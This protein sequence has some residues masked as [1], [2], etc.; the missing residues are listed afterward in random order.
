M[1]WNENF[2]ASVSS[3]WT[4]FNEGLCCKSWVS[5]AMDNAS[6]Y[7]LEDSWLA[8]KILKCLN[9]YAG[10]LFQRL[11][12]TTPNCSQGRHLSFT[13]NNRGRNKEFYGVISFYFT[14]S[15]PL[16]LYDVCR[17]VR[18]LL[19]EKNLS[20]CHREYSFSPSTN[21]QWK[22]LKCRSHKSHERN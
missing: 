5:G 16:L 15:F 22:E 21:T 8:R 17:R 2:K 13:M 10:S 3:Y 12:C 7:G 19:S 4:N 9:T 18:S 11:T 14:L 20:Q 6:D 1:A